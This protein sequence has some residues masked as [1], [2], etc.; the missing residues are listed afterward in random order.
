MG[1]AINRGG[2]PGATT[3]LAPRTVRTI[4]NASAFRGAGTLAGTEAW[5][6]FRQRDEAPRAA[7]GEPPH[8]GG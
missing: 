7:Q 1:W 6:R 2:V 4:L 8:L 5:L 3:A